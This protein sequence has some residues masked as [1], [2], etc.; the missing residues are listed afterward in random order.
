MLIVTLSRNVIP[1]YKHTERSFQSGLRFI[2]G[3]WSE[4]IILPITASLSTA[5]GSIMTHSHNTHSSP[6]VTILSPRSVQL[7][8]TA[9]GSR[10]AIWTKHHRPIIPDA[11][12]GG[13]EEGSSTVPHVH[14]ES[15]SL[16]S[17][18]FLLCSVCQIAIT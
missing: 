13:A 12:S 17:L 9:F 11:T 8:V 7:R 16:S 15:G 6:R 10:G 2:K 14:G 4:D 18:H 1:F 5:A 3:H